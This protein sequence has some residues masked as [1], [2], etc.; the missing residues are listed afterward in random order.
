MDEHGFSSWVIEQIVTAAGKLTSFRDATFAVQ[1]AGISISE[2]QVTRLAHQVG[3]ELIDQRDRQVVE[4]RRRQLPARCLKTPQ[5]VVVEVDGG[6]I[7]TRAAEQKAGVHDAQNKE[8][9]V[10]CLAT[11]TSKSFTED[12]QPEPPASFQNAR[13]VQRLV[14]QMKGQA[15]EAETTEKPEPNE[16]SGKPMAKIGVTERWSPRR[17]VSTC[18]ASMAASASFGPMMAAEAQERHFYAA[19]Q[20]AFVADGLAY[21]WAIH[22]GYFSTFVPIVDFLHVLCYL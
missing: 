6:R 7:R 22:R 14:Q 13:R 1:L 3:Q 10:A 11:L 2:R 8:D 15:G 5:A 12:P 4:H 9:K 21:N 20:R 18:V 16:D 19:K 17:L